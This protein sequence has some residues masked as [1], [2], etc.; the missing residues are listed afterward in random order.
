M[1][2]QPLVNKSKHLL[3]DQDLAN[4]S[5]FTPLPDELGEE[6]DMQSDSR[7]YSTEEEEDSPP[8]INISVKGTM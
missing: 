5:G 8:F 3:K 6:G 1:P 7:K 4:P 2:S